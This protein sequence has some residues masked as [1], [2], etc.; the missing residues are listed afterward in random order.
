MG[1]RSSIPVGPAFLPG[2][3]AE[4]LRRMARDE[5]DAKNS[6][7]YL[8]AHHRKKGKYVTEVAEAVGERCETAR[9]W[10]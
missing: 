1:C 4:D 2:T 5:N 3:S 8:A 9:T 7:K 6:R 10:L